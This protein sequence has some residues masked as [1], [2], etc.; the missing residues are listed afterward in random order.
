MKKLLTDYKSTNFMKL[1]KDHMAQ[2]KQKEGD[3]VVSGSDSEQELM[4]RN[5][6]FYEYK[7]FKKAETAKFQ[8]LINSLKA[9]LQ[10]LEC[11]M[12]SEDVS[13]VTLKNL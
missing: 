7:H 11:E 12:I 10:K 1:F 2:R 6:S 4:M 8:K 9:R 13:Q 3:L 5:E